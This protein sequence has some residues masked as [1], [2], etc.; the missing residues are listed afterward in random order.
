[1]LLRELGDFL[2]V[3]EGL[4][5]YCSHGSMIAEKYMPG[6]SIIIPLRKDRYGVRSR[7]WIRYTKNGLCRDLLSIIA[8]QMNDGDRLGA[9]RT[10]THL[11]Q[12]RP[13]IFLRPE[14]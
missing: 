3:S 9:L 10:F 1:M 8:H 11:F 6:P 5:V 12:L 14:F 4:T 2:Y 7:R 13:R